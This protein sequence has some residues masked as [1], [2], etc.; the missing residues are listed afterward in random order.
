MTTNEIA[1]WVM[2]ERAASA[3]AAHGRVSSACMPGIEK[4][5]KAAALEYDMDEPVVRLEVMDDPPGYS[6]LVNFSRKGRKYELT[7]QIAHAPPKGK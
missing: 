1:P 2:A 6:V 3:M 5:I 7:F 4:A